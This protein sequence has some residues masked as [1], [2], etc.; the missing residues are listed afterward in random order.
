[1]P[2]QAGWLFT[3]HACRHCL[4]TILQRGTKFCCSICRQEAEGKP[5]GI[6]G[7]GFEVD[8]TGTRRRAGFR[9]VPNPSPSAA[10]PARVLIEFGAD[11]G[12]AGAKQ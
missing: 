10:N 12:H 8:G 7:C 9:C 11:A 4:G 3:E 1:M 6:C 2:D 5:E